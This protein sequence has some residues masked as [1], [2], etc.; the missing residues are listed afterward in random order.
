M[1]KPLSVAVQNGKY[2]GCFKVYK[3]G[4]RSFVEN[5]D[6]CRLAINGW[7]YLSANNPCW[8]RAEDADFKIQTRAQ[9]RRNKIANRQEVINYLTVY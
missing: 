8:K 2:H 9:K 7:C 1:F 6:C 5:G 4:T 3:N